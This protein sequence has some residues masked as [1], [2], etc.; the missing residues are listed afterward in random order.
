MKL[1]LQSQ[2][3][4]VWMAVENGYILPDTTPVVGTTERRLM[5]C[6]GKAMYV[7]QGGVIGSEF[8]KVMHCTSAKETWDNLKN[9]YEGDGKVK[10]AKLQTYRRKF[11]YLK[12]KE[13]EDIVAYFLWVDEIVNT[14]RGLGEKVK[15]IGFV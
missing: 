13:D 7:L 14:M 8:V 4:D 10:G 5:E 2:G 9:V 11:E 6:N 12:I 15:N 1:F 3:L